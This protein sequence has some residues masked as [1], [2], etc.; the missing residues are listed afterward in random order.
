MKKILF[1]A[2]SSI[3][4]LSA[5]KKEIK[6][7]EI[8]YEVV[9]KNCSNWNGSYLNENAVVVGVD[10]TGNWKYSF[11]NVNKLG[12]AVIQAYPDGLADDAEAFMKIY[13]N[14]K[15]VAE[16]RSSIS[17]QLMYELP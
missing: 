11:K 13:V 17:P 7:S 6:I 1:I 2:L 5:C 14:G 8:T 4:M 9:L 10:V 12:A 3:V 16:G 15:L